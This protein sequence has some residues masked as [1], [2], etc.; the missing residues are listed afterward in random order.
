MSF[1][2]I[3]HILRTIWTLPVNRLRHREELRTG[4]MTNAHFYYGLF[5]EKESTDRHH[6]RTIRSL[7]D[8][9]T[10]RCRVR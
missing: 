2:K 6:L 5:E 1:L 7:K 4:T 10:R 8:G 9:T 3:P